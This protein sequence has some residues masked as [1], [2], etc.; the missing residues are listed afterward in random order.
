MVGPPGCGKSM[1]SETFP[2][3]T[4]EAQLE[5]IS[6][7]ELAGMGYEDSRLSSTLCRT[8]SVLIS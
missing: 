8:P 7:Y 6:L 5:K 1:L 4:K 2:P 3:L